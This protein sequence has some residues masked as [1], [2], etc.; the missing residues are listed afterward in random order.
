MSGSQYFDACELEEQD[1]DSSPFRWKLTRSPGSRQKTQLQSAR[2]D[3]EEP[4][5]KVGCTQISGKLIGC[6][7]VENLWLD[8]H[9]SKRQCSCARK[10]RAP[11][12]SQCETRGWCGLSFLAALSRG[13]C[14]AGLRH[15]CSLDVHPQRV[16]FKTK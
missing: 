2:Q 9:V 8:V 5:N 7:Q 11:K 14:Q 3:T 15:N 12:A 4:Y 6:V 16:L 13:R 10:C 1:C